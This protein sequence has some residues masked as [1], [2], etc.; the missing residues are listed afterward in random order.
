M[1]LLIRDIYFH[2][3]W[4]IS[5]VKNYLSHDIKLINNFGLIF[6]GRNPTACVH[7]PFGLAYTGS[8]VGLSI[9]IYALLVHKNGNTRRLFLGKVG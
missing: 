7:C 9:P 6:F 4:L 8:R 1:N 5:D 3:I 2:D